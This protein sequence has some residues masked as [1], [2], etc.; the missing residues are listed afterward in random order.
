MRQVDKLLCLR[1]D[2]AHTYESDGYLA[3]GSAIEAEKAL[4]GLKGKANDLIDPCS[5]YG[6]IE[7]EIWLCEP[8]SFAA[9]LSI[10]MGRRVEGI[11]FMRHR[12]FIN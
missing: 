10:G 12:E 1:T 8:A 9:P 7:L 4:E 11:Q 5:E 3:F 6:Y 2:D